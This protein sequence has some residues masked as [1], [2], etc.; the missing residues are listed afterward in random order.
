LLASAGYADIDEQRRSAARV[1]RLAHLVL[2]LDRWEGFTTTLGEIDGG[3]LTDVVLTLLREGGS[4]GLHVVITGDRTLLSGRISTTTDDKICFRLAD[5]G[6]YTLLGLNPRSL[7][8]DV[9]A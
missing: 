4:A 8:D 5:R 3:R 7:P 6:D 9:P 1:E 2:L